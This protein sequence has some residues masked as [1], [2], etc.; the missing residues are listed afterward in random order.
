RML[1]LLL[2]I[3]IYEVVR[4]I[5]YLGIVVAVVVTFFGLGA[6]W[7]AML[8]MR[9]GE[10]SPEEPPEAFARPEVPSMIDPQDSDEAEENEA[11]ETEAKEPDEVDSDDE[12]NPPDDEKKPAARKTRGTTKDS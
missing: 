6:A 4:A 12:G 3:L 9:R 1:N 2:G 10:I 7:M 11:T 8:K 5:P